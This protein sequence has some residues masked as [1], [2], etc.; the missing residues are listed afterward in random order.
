MGGKMKYHVHMYKIEG[1][2]ECDLEADSE[3]EARQ[4]AI[5]I[6]K[7]GISEYELREPDTEYITMAFPK[8]D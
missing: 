1:L 2:V 7:Y 3:L 4:K 6:L 5:E 8:G